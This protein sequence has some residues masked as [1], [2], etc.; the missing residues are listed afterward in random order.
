MST[1]RPALASRLVL[2]LGLAFGAAAIQTPAHA[3][4]AS[5]AASTSAFQ[6]MPDDPHA[7]VVRARGDGVAD[8]SAAIQAAIDQAANKGEGGLVFLPSGRYRITRSILIPLAVRVY[9]VGK[10]RP[11]FVLGANTPGFQKGVANMVIFT[12]GDQ[13]T[14]G[15]VPMPVQGEVPF[16]GKVRDAN[17]ATFYSALSNVDFEIGDGNPA[18]TAV[19]MHTAQHSNLSHIDFHTGSGLAGVYQVGNIAYDLRFFGGR[20]GILAEKTS[21]AWQF[22]LLDAQFDGQRDAAIRE[23]E[24]GLTL[25]NTAIRNTPVGIEIDRGYGDW[26]WGRDVRF[27]N[28]AK[29]ALVVSNEDNVYTQ[30]GFENASARKV[31]TFVRFRDS[32]KTLAGA[33]AGGAYKVDAFNYGLTLQDMGTPGRFATTYKT[34]PLSAVAAPAAATA[35]AA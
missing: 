32:G 35:T 34:S 15:K 24:A 3:A 11:V 8:D 5:T 31:P 6:Q 19:R 20:Y 27:D 9:G 2:S 1:S 7:V 14:V 33:N 30:V 10:T 18:A 29:S 21:P 12:G 16:S 13:Y 22:T 25:V 23:H 28:V 4:S 17:S 26:L